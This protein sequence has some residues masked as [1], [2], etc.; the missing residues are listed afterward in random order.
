MEV[1]GLYCP[2]SNTVYPKMKIGEYYQIPNFTKKHI[3]L[4]MPTV[5]PNTSHEEVSHF[6]A[7]LK[8][9]L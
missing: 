9:W 8:E 2:T 7:K 1:G 4:T 6:P 3:S 5:S